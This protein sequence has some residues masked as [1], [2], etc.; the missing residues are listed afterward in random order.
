[1]IKRSVPG[2]ESIIAMTGTLAGRFATRESRCYDL[3]CSLGASLLAM[4]RATRD[5]HCH[6]TGIDNSPQM[7]DR[8]RLILNGC[9]DTGAAELICGDIRAIGIENASVV[10]LNFTLQFI[11]VAERQQLLDRICSG[12]NP[13]GILVLSEKV[14]FSDSHHDQLM[15]DL[16]HN[17]KRAQGYTELEISQK[18]NALENV[19]IPETL[20]VHRQRLRRSGFHSV[21]VWFQCFNFASLLAIKASSHR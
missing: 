16:H 5:R 2:Y 9:G 11:P 17:F 15:I 21:D 13:G 18:R 4:W 10:V 12:L 19:L 14:S 8:C 7:I 6:I 3:G 20:E 1:M